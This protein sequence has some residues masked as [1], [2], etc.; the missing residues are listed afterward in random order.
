MVSTL[1]RARYRQ[2]QPL[3]VGGQVESVLTRPIGQFRL[4]ACDHG[5][6]WRTQTRSRP[7]DRPANEATRSRNDR[8]G[9][10]PDPARRCAGPLAGALCSLRATRALARPALVANQPG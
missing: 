4:S 6:S 1:A 5:Q 2:I 9:E 8:A 3:M 7:K 10:V